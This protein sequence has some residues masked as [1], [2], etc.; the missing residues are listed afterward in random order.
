[1]NRIIKTV[2]I[3]GLL[4]M[5]SVAI[6]ALTNRFLM[7]SQTSNFTK[8]EIF[9]FDL[10]TGLA[11]AEIG[12]NDSLNIE[13]VIYNDATEEMYAFISIE[14]PSTSKGPLYIYD[15]GESWTE[16]ENKDGLAV[17]AYAENGVMTPL[18]PGET[19]IALTSQIT[20][21]GIENYE[22]AAIDDINFT[23][24]GYVI[25]TEDIDVDP[26]SA[27]GQCKELKENS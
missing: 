13:P 8:K 14:T 27:W 6:Y 3:I 7:I 5:G 18:Q 17:Y 24:T 16:V 25:S 22:Y 26:S 10:S 2:M 23:V 4:L 9:E 1:M 15:V 20:M 19:T 21:A 12:P 11:D